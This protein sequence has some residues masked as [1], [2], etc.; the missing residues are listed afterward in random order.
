VTNHCLLSRFGKRGPPGGAGAAVSLWLFYGASAQHP[1]IDLPID[2]GE[3]LMDLW[4]VALL[5]TLGASTWGLV[6]LFER[7]LGRRG[8]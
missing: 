7:L 1:P 4:L 8:D 2:T 3:T 5:L 6:V